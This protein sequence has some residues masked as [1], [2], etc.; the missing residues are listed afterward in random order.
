MA[1]DMQALNLLSRDPAICDL[2][3]SEQDVRLLWS[4]AQIPDFRK[5]MASE[6]SGLVG[7]IFTFC[8]TRPASFHP[9]MDEQIGRCDRVEGDLD[10]LSTRLAHI[11]TWTYVANRNDWLDDPSTGRNVAERLKTACRMPCT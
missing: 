1:D 6:H 10:T 4:V 11:R 9:L 2:A 7:E 5:T 8:D 3:A